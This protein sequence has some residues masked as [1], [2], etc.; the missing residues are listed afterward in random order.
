[1]NLGKPCLTFSLGVA[2]VFALLCPVD[3]R[4]AGCGKIK[5]DATDAVAAAPV[6]HKVILEND[7]V[8]VL[9]ATVPL[10]S[11]EVPT[12]IFGRACSSSKPPALMSR[13]RR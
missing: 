11:K 2:V 9:E 10:H 6:N 7:T 5:P 1:M 13:G 4:A 3:L 8:R 12:R